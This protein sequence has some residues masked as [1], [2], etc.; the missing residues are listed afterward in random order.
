[1]S[2]IWGEIQTFNFGYVHYKFKSLPVE[3]PT[4]H[5]IRLDAVAVF[6]TSFHLLTLYWEVRSCFLGA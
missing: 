6:G 1:M 5:C 3:F 4:P 2:A